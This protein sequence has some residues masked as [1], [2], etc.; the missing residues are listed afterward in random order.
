[1]VAGQSS[2]HLDERRSE[3]PLSGESRRYF[4][5]AETQGFEIGVAPNPPGEGDC[6][7]GEA[8]C[9]GR[10]GME[11]R[12]PVGASPETHDREYDGNKQSTGILF[13]EDC[14]EQKGPGDH[15]EE[16]VPPAVASRLK[17]QP[18]CDRVKRKAELLV[19]QR[20]ER[21]LEPERGEA[22]ARQAG[23]R[24]AGKE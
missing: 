3:H 23:E 22:A 10:E 15:P 11:E 16:Y 7:E 12:S 5:S 24:P 14:A 6:A 19:Q 8:G 9:H 20:S 1:M 4:D 17:Q 18:H 13:R 2:Y 21:S